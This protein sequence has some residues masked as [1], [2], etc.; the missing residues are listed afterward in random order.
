MGHLERERV[1]ELCRQRLIG[2]VM[3]RTLLTTSEKNV[4]V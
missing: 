3:K 4:N 2:Q 1:I